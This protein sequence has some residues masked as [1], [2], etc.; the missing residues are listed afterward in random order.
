MADAAAAG[1]ATV[2]HA[3]PDYISPDVAKTLASLFRERVRRT[4]EACAYRYFDEADG[5]WKDS[6]WSEMTVQ[7]ARWQA[8]LE[9]E[10]LHAGDRVAVMLRNCREWVMFDQAAHGLGLVVVPVYTNDR[11]ESVAYILQDAGV[12]LLLI[13]GPEHWETLRP[14][15]A[16]LSGLVRILTLLPVQ[17][18]D[19]DLRLQWTG[20]WLPKDAGELRARDSD[21]EAL[22]TIVYTSGTTGRPK[23]VMLSHRNIVWNAYASLQCFTAT[24][25][26]LFLSFLPLSHTF[27][28]TVG[29]YVPMMAGTTVAYARSITLLAE[30]MLAV[31]PTVFITVPRI[32]ERVYAKIQTQLQEKP[33]LA[34][35]L[36][37]WTVALGWR[38]FQY[39][40]RRAPW[41]PWLW[42]WPLLDALV[43]RKILV[44]MG[45]RLRIAISGGAP[46][47]FSIARIFI[48]L[49]LPILQGYG[50]TETG[51][52]ISV[53]R[54]DDND[55]ASVGSP[56]P[57]VELRTG[58]NQEL[59]IKSPGVMPGYWNR[60]EATA[61]MIDAQ[62]W[63]HTGDQVRIERGHVYITGRLKEIIVLANGEKV[64]PADMEMAIAMDPLFDHVMVIGEGR[65]YLSALL[66]LNP[67]RW[68]KL[69]S[70]LNLDPDSAA[71]LNDPRLHERILERIG[72][73]LRSFP[74]YAQIRR[75]ALTLE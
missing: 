61:Q 28:R 73:R 71:V 6:S 24:R 5:T 12:K 56:L 34:R 19:S 3:A 63:V 55:P 41:T 46:L 16:Q 26:D 35:R 52:A 42:F 15:H 25:D 51:P 62:G 39:Q 14:I 23:G 2:S 48:G 8:G 7:V 29:Y 47:S 70:E 9:R 64:P 13:E 27:E 45:G 66:V 59:L 31:R 50:L 18:S 33:A 65:P 10:P 72:K 36:F 44:R 30:D 17:S 74:G 60:P 21:P 37:Q 69:A 43:A 67:Q 40:Q 11:A 38:R 20:D 58:D 54:V 22:A 57:D 68:E 4:P 32:F 75:V 1:C 53:N 49:G